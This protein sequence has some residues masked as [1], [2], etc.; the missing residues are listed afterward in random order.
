MTRSEAPTKPS[1]AGLQQPVKTR[2]SFTRR[3]TAS[4]GPIAD[5][6]LPDKNRKSADVRPGGLHNWNVH[7][8]MVILA[9]RQALS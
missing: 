4:N 9:Q 5:W 7:G 3:I 6:Q 1:F 8:T 2:R